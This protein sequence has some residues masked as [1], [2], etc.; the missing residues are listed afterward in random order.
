MAR[1][2]PKIA[3]LAQL[4]LFE[5]CTAKELLEIGAHLDE[6]SLPAGATLTHEGAVEP[7]AFLLASGRAEVRAHDVV[8]A[9]VKA[10]ELVGEISLLDR[11]RSR[12]ATVTALTP[13][14]AFV[15]TPRD[16]ASILHTSPR[17][18]ERVHRE[19]ARRSA[20]LDALAS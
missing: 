20:A 3:R 15:L 6:V 16:L 4:P 5:G 12:T 11:T 17:V 1:I 14:V 19:W 9:E 18:A 10:G 13:V 8:V 7:Q 2:D